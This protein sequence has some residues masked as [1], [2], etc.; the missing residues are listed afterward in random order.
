VDNAANRDTKVEREACEVMCSEEFEAAVL[1]FLLSCSWDAPGAETAPFTAEKENN[2]PGATESTNSATKKQHTAKL[3]SSWFTD[4]KKWAKDLQMVIS[5]P[6]AP[7]DA[8]VKA[9]RLIKVYNERQILFC[10]KKQTHL[11]EEAKKILSDDLCFMEKMPL[12][13]EKNCAGDGTTCG[14]TEETTGD[15]AELMDYGWI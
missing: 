14:E 11:F 3:T 9:S 1:A 5:N 13:G 15:Y 8:R 6:K 4:K 7:A 2:I 12:M 10:P